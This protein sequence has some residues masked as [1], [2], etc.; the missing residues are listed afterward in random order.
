MSDNER[1]GAADASGPSLV[2]Q[3]RRHW[4]IIALC[5]IVAAAAAYG[6]SSR[7]AETY[8]ATSLLLVQ[9]SSPA[10]TIIGAGAPLDSGSQARSAETVAALSRARPIAVATARRIGGLTA[11][12]VSNKV[13]LAA[14]AADNVL[15]AQGT[16]SSPTR[17]ARL[18]NAFVAV[19]ISQDTD[20]R[21]RAV[22]AA[23]KTLQRRYMRL[24]AIAKNQA[25]GR[26]LRGRIAD[27]RAL[28][29]VGAG[30]L[31]I[32][33]GATPPSHSNDS[34]RRDGILG[35]LFGLLLGCGVAL[36][37]EGADRRVRRGDDLESVV[38][39]P[40]LASV[41]DSRLLRRSTPVGELGPGERE[42]FLLLWTQLRYGRDAD[43]VRRVL[44]TSSGPQEGKSTVSWY[45]ASAAAMSGAKTLLVEADARR[46][47]LGKRHDIPEH[48][49][50][51]AFLEGHVSLADAIAH[52]PVGA[53]AN[54]RAAPHTLDVLAVSEQS[55]ELISVQ[56]TDRLTRMLADEV[57]AY[58]LVVV[59]APPLAL[60]AEATPLATVVDGVL[61][62]SR[63]NHTDRSGLMAVR[64]QLDRVGANPL[65]L[66]L[67]GGAAQSYY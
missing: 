41:P 37:R 52:V 49:G 26:Q 22:R 35:G 60:A 28:E 48:P 24:S 53:S 4:V 20:R 61:I 54:G 58:D 5:G 27:L 39:L 44:V 3:L 31:S 56:A 45:L 19:F 43:P 29:L 67:D 33:Q 16:E 7:R 25:A 40:V 21:Q 17:A 14:G 55:Y 18:V 32:V 13:S 9:P 38:G 12:D 51:F 8:T 50:L 36:V 34:S 2:A 23:R 65:G 11:D 47:V 10:T 15:K 64:E 59:D 42:G 62:V 63:P 57:F 6:L 30:Q 46:P 66:V 1:T